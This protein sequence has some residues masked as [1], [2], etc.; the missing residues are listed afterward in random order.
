MSENRIGRWFVD[1]TDPTRW[2]GPVME[3]EPDAVLAR[4]TRELAEARAAC[5]VM[6]EDV[7]TALFESRDLMVELRD[8]IAHLTKGWR[9]SSPVQSL[10]DELARL[11]QLEAAVMDDSLGRIR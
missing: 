8:S 7:R 9:T 2:I 4:L 6:V 5:A 11:R 3:Y 1:A 10:L